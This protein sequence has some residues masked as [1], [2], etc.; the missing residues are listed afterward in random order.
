M[1][2]QA[3]RRTKIRPPRRRPDTLSR[4][5]L[6][7]AFQD[8]LD[9]KLI[10]I[11]A[12]AGYGKT[13]L[14][15]DSLHQVDLPVCWYTLDALDTT[16]QHFLSHFIATIAHQFP[17]C[18]EK[19][20]I[21]LQ[22]LSADHLA[23]DQLVTILT[24]ELYDQ[25]EEH[26]IIVLDNYRSS[27]FVNEFLNLFV[28]FVDE[29]CHVVVT[30]RSILDFPDLVLLIGRSLVGGLG[31]NDLAFRPAE[32]Q[33]LMQQN[34]DLVISE[35]EAQ[36]IV[37]ETEGWITG[38]L[39]SAQTSDKQADQ[40]LTNEMRVAKLNGVNVYDYLAQQVLNQQPPPVR[41][42]LLQTSLLEEFDSALCQ[43]VLG[44]LY[45]AQ[46]W[47][48]LID[49]LLDNNLFVIPVD[50]DSQTDSQTV[51]IRYHHLFGEFLQI[52]VK[53]ELPEAW[54]QILGRLAEV[55]LADQAWES[56]YQVYQKL[57]EAEATIK[58]IEQSG[59]T[60]IRQGRY[61]LL[62]GWIQAL[63]PQLLDNRPAILSISGLVEAVLGELP[64]GLTLLNRAI[65]M[66]RQA[67]KTHLLTHSLER[68][69]VTHRLLGNHQASWTDANEVLALIEDGVVDGDDDEL[70]HLKAKALRAKGIIHQERGEL[71]QAEPYLIQSLDIYLTLAEPHNAAMSQV[72]LG[73]LYE[74]SGLYNQAIST[75]QTALNFWI[76]SDNLI[77]Q[78]NILNNM[79]VVYH[80][81]GKYTLAISTLKEAIDLAIKTGY[82]RI[83]AFANVSLGDVYLDLGFL[84]MAEVMYRQDV[85]T[86]TKINERFLHFYL[87]LAQAK[88]ATIRASPPLAQD[89]LKQAADLAQD[90]SNYE[91]GVYHLT[92]GY[93]SLAQKTFQVAIDHLQKTLNYL[94][95]SRQFI[96]IIKAHLYLASAYHGLKDKQAAWEYLQQVFQLSASL[97][98]EHPIVQA[99]SEAKSLLAAFK[100]K[101]EVSL[102]SKKVNLL[103][104]TISEIRRSY[105]D[106]LDRGRDDGVADDQP[107]IHIQTLGDVMVRIGPEISV[108]AGE[109]RKQ[110]LIFDFFFYILANP[111]GYSR[112]ALIERFWPDESPEKTKKHFKNITYRIRRMLRKD[113]L[114]FNDVENCYQFN[115]ALNYVYDV[116][117]FEDKAKQIMSGQPGADMQQ[118][119][120]QMVQVYQGP[121]LK[122]MSNHWVETERVRLSQA[123]ITSSLK[124][125]NYHFEQQELE[126]A[127]K[128]CQN[129]LQEDVCLEEAHR[130][131]MKIHAERGNRAAVVR[132]FDTCQE[133]LRE[134]IDFPVSEQTQALY[135]DLTSYRRW[136]E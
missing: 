104:K 50:T 9:A 2:L 3:V 127:L 97:E 35:A 80:L 5:R 85:K 134:E 1:D 91:M 42:F 54:G 95:D 76:N 7:A 103:K 31:L 62:Q 26:F 14:L 69:T 75:Y 81:Q 38:V 124:A 55:Y 29:N 23:L 84:D 78:A 82:H 18:G 125:A 39:L 74:A 136:R 12:P 132:Q 130:L 45:G 122:I 88:L 30:S 96:E 135:E 83:E 94:N 17:A 6:L 116:E 65:T 51:W 71:S 114:I 34:H 13:T 41:Q 111:R 46:D 40:G 57:G 25:I 63:S 133:V 121:Y 112:V 105:R 36:S 61:D 37:H 106:E 117:V 19:T 101:P 24:N 44:P 21:Y 58:M 60:L 89:F 107:V 123:Y 129:M 4:P 118:L 115:R 10:L 11:T 52:Q 90:D 68:R 28:Q 33:A 102:L 59:L 56:A 92:W 70:L 27:R 110:P 72:E 22:N 43:T 79:G 32:I 20:R 100:K 86:T 98:S 16:P 48:S 99:A 131:A 128:I 119:Y 73:R 113:I 109:W 66:A 47:A 64:D 15:V 108:N 8:L 120:E 93:L 49:T 77:W 87:S 53:T 126:I 67:N